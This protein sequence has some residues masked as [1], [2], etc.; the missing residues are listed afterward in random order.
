MDNSTLGGMPP[1]DT[2]DFIFR[3]SIR[4]RNGKRIYARHYGLTAF[5]IRI[6]KKPPPKQPKLPG[7][8]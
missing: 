2:E 8:E 1:E 7:F 3:S 6:R 5:R 4:T